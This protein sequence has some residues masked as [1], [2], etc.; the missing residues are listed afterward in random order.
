MSYIFSDRISALAPSAIREILKSSGDPD[1]I[2]FAAG[3]PS[4]E[5]FPASEMA[6]IAAKIFADNAA[7]A[8]QYG[9]SEGY[10][11][12][13]ERAAARLREKYSTGTD[14]DSLIIT[15]GAQQAIELFTKAVLNEGDAIICEEPSFIGSLNAF[16]SYNA[17]LVGVPC[18]ANGMDIDALEEAL[19]TTPRVKFIYTIPTFQNP[20]GAVM[21]LEN[22]V[23]LLVL[24]E[25]YGVM[26]LE[27]S[28]YFELRYEGEPVPSIKSLDTSG[29]VMYAGS[30]SKIIAPGIRLGLALGPSEIISKMTVAKQVS[31]VH[32][33]L[34]FQILVD[35]YLAEYDI[36]A[37]IARCRELYR[38]RRDEMDKALRAET[39]GRLRW[40]I[41]QGGLF[42][43]GELDGIDGAEFCAKA[44]DRKV[45]AVPGEAFAVN[46]GVKSPGIRLNFSLPSLEQIKTG[47]ARLAQALKE[48][49]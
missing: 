30:W 48:F 17:R 44:K 16:R 32:S 11:P 8:L 23:R 22:R 46:P 33:N 15:S 29:R 34:F 18:G 47:T 40:S 10:T 24:A 7:G 6:E 43:W 25:K 39:A 37:H 35:R 36:D 14:S 27:D 26:I 21:P 28:P 42:L 19:K 38:V 41:P 12:L 5:A 13:R 31:D 3:N 45:T 2:P 9:I 1:V 20:T 49:K 4:P